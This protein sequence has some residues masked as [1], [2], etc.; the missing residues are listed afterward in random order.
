M[1]LLEL[2]ADPAAWAAP[3]VIRNSIPVPLSKNAAH[4]E[5]VWTNF[6]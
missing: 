3:F 2:A 6:L 1:T 4:A 5:F